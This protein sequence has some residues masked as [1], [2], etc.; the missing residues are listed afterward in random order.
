VSAL[1]KY[2]SGSVSLAPE[3]SVLANLCRQLIGS[4]LRA[5]FPDVANRKPFGNFKQFF[6][7]FGHRVLYSQAAL[8]L[9]V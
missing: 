9:A 5:H 8:Q 3:F 7:F 1:A 6:F 2:F 4:C